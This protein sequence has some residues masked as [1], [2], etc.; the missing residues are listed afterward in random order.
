MDNEVILDILNDVVCY[1]DT[2]LKPALIDDDKIKQTPVNIA[3][4]IEQAPV[5]KNSKEQ[6]VLQQTRLLIELLPEIVNTIKQ[7]NQL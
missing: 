3:K 2:A 1:V 4:R 5:E 7:I 6:Q